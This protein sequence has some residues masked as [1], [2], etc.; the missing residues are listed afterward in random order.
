MDVA[1]GE[2]ALLPGGLP[3]AGQDAGLVVE[4]VKSVV[5]DHEIDRRLGNRP[6]RRR[7]VETDELRLFADHPVTGHP[8]LGEDHVRA[9]DLHAP[10][11]QFTQVM[12]DAA[13]KLERTDRVVPV[14]LQQAQA[15]QEGRVGPAVDEVVA[16]AAPAEPVH[17]LPQGGARALPNQPAQGLRVGR[18]T[19]PPIVLIG[20][21]EDE[22]VLPP[23][24]LKMIERCRDEAV[25][26]GAKIGNAI[27]D[28]PAG[29]GFGVAQGMRAVGLEPVAGLRREEIEGDHE[30]GF[31]RTARDVTGCA[32]R[33]ERDPGKP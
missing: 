21:Q 6:M 20:Q 15:R 5:A 27:D 11:L 23:I 12:A 3:Q 25:A 31:C 16:D 24:G 19:G 22:R 33:S 26:A 2:P 4:E 29:S 9:R 18:R 30:P 14:R 7:R 28:R 13:G 8:K 32:Y 1:E 10:A 17:G